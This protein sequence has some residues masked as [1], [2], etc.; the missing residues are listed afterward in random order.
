MKDN[1]FKIGSNRTFEV[2]HENDGTIEIYESEDPSHTGHFFN[3]I[4]EL[5]LYINNLAD[6]AKK[7]K[8]E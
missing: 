6:I 5:Y 8:G 1:V 7:I 4:Q 2:L 3:S